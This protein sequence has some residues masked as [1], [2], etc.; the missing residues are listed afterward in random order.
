M[1]TGIWEIRN[2]ARVIQIKVGEHDVP[3]VPRRKTQSLNLPN[4]GLTLFQ[5]RPGQTCIDAT[6]SLTATAHVIEAKARIN[7]HQPSI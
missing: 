4:G 7:E 1:D 2:S 5:H 3:N 6:K